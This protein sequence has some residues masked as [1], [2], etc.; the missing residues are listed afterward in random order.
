VDSFSR[1]A[2]ATGRDFTAEGLSHNRAMPFPRR[3]ASPYHRPM[4]VRVFALRQR[5]RRTGGYGS[6]A[7]QGIAGSIGMYTQLHGDRS[8]A[9][10]TLKGSAPKEPDL[11]PPLYE[12]V[13]V[14]LTNQGLLLRGYE[15]VEGAAYVQEWRCEFE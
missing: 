14:A 8:I 7:P 12:P 15:S 3:A 4:R 5:G 1:P 11:L 9:A 6:L 10:A 13:L 2:G